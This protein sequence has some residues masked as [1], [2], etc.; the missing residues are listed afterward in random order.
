MFHSRWLF[1]GILLFIGLVMMD[2]TE[3]GRF[4]FARVRVSEM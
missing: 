2:E 1:T 4:L 3:S